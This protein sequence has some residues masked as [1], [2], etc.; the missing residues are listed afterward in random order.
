MAQE[1]ASRYSRAA[2]AERADPRRAGC[3][4]PTPND[5][6]NFLLLLQQIRAAFGKQL[7]TAAVS[8]TGFNGPD[9]EP[10]K[11]VSAFAEVLDYL[12]IMAVSFLGSYESAKTDQGPNAQYDVS[13]ASWSETT[14]PLAPLRSCS[15]GVGVESSIDVWTG[16]GFPASQLLLCVL[17]APWCRA[18]G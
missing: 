11:D 12:M 8:M 3:N 10:V 4:S 7:V 16:A 18:S 2:C 1:W 15:S 9:G 14:G 13:G 6:A 5:T 17:P